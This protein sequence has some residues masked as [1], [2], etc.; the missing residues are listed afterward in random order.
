MNRICLIINLI[1]N[2]N[3]ENSLRGFQFYD[4]VK[5]KKP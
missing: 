4:F 5:K 1:S 3:L 2:F